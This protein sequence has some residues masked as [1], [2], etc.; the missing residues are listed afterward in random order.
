MLYEAL[1]YSKKYQIH[2][3]KT[4]SV[5]NIS[6]YKLNEKLKLTLG[7]NVIEISDSSVHLGLTRAGKKVIGI[8]RQ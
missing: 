4:K 2:P 3:L 7:D 1:I 8:Q 5:V 6:I